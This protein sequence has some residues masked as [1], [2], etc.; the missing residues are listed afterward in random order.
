MTSDYV[1]RRMSAFFA[2]GKCCVYLF[3]LFVLLTSK[4]SKLLKSTACL[5][6]AIPFTIHILF[7]FLTIIIYFLCELTCMSYL[8]VIN[9]L[10]FLYF[11]GLICLCKQ[12]TCMMGL[13]STL[14][15]TGD[16]F[17]YFSA[18]KYKK[19]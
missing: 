16:C 15:S 9:Q 14:T 1:C 7:F 3:V 13:A 10:Y 4:T 5:E 19:Q 18:K 8:L 11:F 6:K 12:S 2:S 17:F